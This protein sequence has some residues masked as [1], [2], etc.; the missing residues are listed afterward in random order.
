MEFSMETFRYFED[1]QLI[2]QLPLDRFVTSK[3]T[4]DLLF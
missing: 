4:Y 1:K 2:H 3:I